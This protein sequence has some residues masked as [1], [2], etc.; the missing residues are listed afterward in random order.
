MDRQDLQDNK[1]DSFPKF[2]LN[3][4][5]IHVKI[6]FP[7]FLLL[8]G[9]GQQTSLPQVIWSGYR[10]SDF[11]GVAAF[12][13]VERFLHAGSGIAGSPE[14]LKS[15]NYILSRLQEKGVS[16]SLDTFEDSTP[17]GIKTFRNVMGVIPGKQD[18]LIIL[19]AHYDLKS[20]IES[21]VGANDSG[22]GVG[23]LLALASLLKAAP[24]GGP[25]VWL[26][27][28]DGEEC[29]VSYGANDGLHGSRHLAGKLVAE[30]KATKVQAFILADMIGDKNLSVTI[31]R[32]SD[33]GLM[34][35]VFKAA[36]E[37]GTRAAFSLCDYSILDDHQPFLDKG[38]PAIDLIDFQYG[39]AP[40]LNDY[41][42]TAADTLDKLSPES[43]EIVG[44]VVL[45][46]ISGLSSD[47]MDQSQPFDRIQGSRGA[48][49]PH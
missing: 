1:R 2:I 32:N 28:L 26:V 22:S 23:L 9:C 17:D 41:W 47:P 8:V 16:T 48:P 7:S 6:L 20:G 12:S 3:I 27:F 45:R 46:V 19:G 14:A 42:H 38:I 35:A 34:L 30:G 11:K 10:A 24:A 15:A 33:P 18:R 13:E 49:L 4:M 25:E 39:S 44:Q 5:F 37:A 36:T 21:F 43:L 31:P 40:R 29:R